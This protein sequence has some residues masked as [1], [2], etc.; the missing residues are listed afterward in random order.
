MHQEWCANLVPF[1][2]YLWIKNDHF[3]SL[4]GK[5][6]DSHERRINSGLSHSFTTSH[7]TASRIC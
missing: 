3:L 2:V 5:A 6:G 7:K 1:L 4:T